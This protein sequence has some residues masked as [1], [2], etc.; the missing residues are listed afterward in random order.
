MELLVRNGKISGVGLTIRQLVFSDPE[1]DFPLDHTYKSSGPLEEAIEQNPNAVGMTGISS[2]R[3]RDFKILK[4]DGKEPSFDNIKTGAY[5]LYRPLFL[6]IDRQSA[7]VAELD[8]FLAFSHS[9][10]RRKIIR[11]NGV[12][13]YL[14]ALSLTF[15][16]REQWNSSRKKTSK[17]VFSGGYLNIMEML[18]PPRTLCSISSDPS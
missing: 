4:L 18:A 14:E 17:S 5:M 16:Q 13:P 8:K 6:L 11:K 15:K 10:E 9:K 12:V 7:N 2:G 3:K 1:M